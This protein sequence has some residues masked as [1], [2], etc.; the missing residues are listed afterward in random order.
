MWQSIT[1]F[2][3]ILH[4]DMLTRVTGQQN[5]SR[6]I[7]HLCGCRQMQ[8]TGIH[9]KNLK[10][11]LGLLLIFHLLTQFL[12]QMWE[13]KTSIMPG[14]LCRESAENSVFPFGELVERTTRL[15]QVEEAFMV[16][17]WAF[18]AFTPLS[19]PW[20]CWESCEIFFSQFFPLC[21]NVLNTDHL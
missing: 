20:S 14:M 4:S 13:L 16:L 2:S 8:R 10:N 11:M 17:W 7:H 21:H 1:F 15:E 5:R 19:L 9:L 3:P 12:C 6:N 18:K